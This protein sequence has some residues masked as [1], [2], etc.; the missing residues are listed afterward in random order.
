MAWDQELTLWTLERG[1]DKLVTS[2]TSNDARGQRSVHDPVTKL[3]NWCNVIYLAPAQGLVVTSVSGVAQDQELS[4]QALKR[5]LM[6]TT[7]QYLLKW[8]S[9]SKI[10]PWSYLGLI[11]LTKLTNWCN[12]NYLAHAQGLVIASVGARRGSRSR[13]DFTSTREGSDVDIR[14]SSRLQINQPVLSSRQ[15]HRHPPV[16]LRVTG[17][18]CWNL[19]PHLS[20]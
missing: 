11:L 14:T 1:D 19:L 10:C 3:T 16:K 20:I 5:S 15:N 4:L 12:A 8:C 18:R 9:R 17:W 13:I 6:L 2:R 7:N